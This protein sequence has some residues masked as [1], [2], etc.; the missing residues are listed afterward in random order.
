MK[1]ETPT[2]TALHHESDLLEIE[3]LVARRADEL[4]RARQALGLPPD[5][6]RCWFEAE[7]EVLAGAALTA[8]A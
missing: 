7:D 3:I 5:D 2:P 6:L 4:A 1:N 8:V